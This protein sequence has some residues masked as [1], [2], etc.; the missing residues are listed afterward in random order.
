MGK[1]TLLFLLFL[2]SYCSPKA[3]QKPSVK[4]VLIASHLN[5][6]VAMNCPK[7]GSGRIFICEQT[8][9]IKIIKNGKVLP[10][11]FL[12]VSTK[13]VPITGRYSER[14]LLG[15]SFHPDYK[16]NKR[17]FIYFS[18]ATNNPASD[19]K[20]I[21]AEFRASAEPDIA[22][23]ASF[24]TIIEIEQ[25]E[26][27]H[28]GGQLAFGPDGFL[29]IG[30]GDGG[31]GGDQHGRIGN[32]QNLNTHLGKILRIDV[33]SKSPYAVPRDNPFVNK[34]NTKPEIW[35][36]GL[37]NPWRFSFDRQ[38]G[39]L[40][41][42]DVGQHKWEEISIIE[43]GKNYGWRIM[44]GSH[45]YEPSTNCNQK[46]LTLPIAEYGHNPL[47]SITGGYVYRGKKIPSLRGKYIFADWS[48]PMFYIEATGS[49]AEIKK[50]LIQGKT[51]NDP[52]MDVNSFG[53]DEQGE[54]YILG[55]ESTGPKSTN[56]IVYLISKAE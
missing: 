2:F 18:S 51:G 11:P 9:K 1:H 35:A 3:Q 28:N 12:D 46:G 22:D 43:K 19:H 37:R 41:C 20:S 15:I 24:K 6:P 50:L 38:N 36:Y 42:A 4:L 29:Y 30:L 49:K 17:F 7:D 44:E 47:L 5:A 45:C 21:V 54:I 16:N 10:K 8:G 23:P 52:K 56:G 48:G 14:G 26:N 27:N 53:E 39:K 33:N 55:Q 31:G 34:P 32:G 13:L 40:Y 25:P